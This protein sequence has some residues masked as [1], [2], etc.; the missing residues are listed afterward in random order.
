MAASAQYK[1][2]SK[3]ALEKAVAEGYYISI[4]PD[5]KSHSPKHISNHHNIW[6]APAKT[7]VAGRTSQGNPALI[8]NPAYGIVGTRQALDAVYPQIIREVHNQEATPAALAEVRDSEISSAQERDFEIPGTPAYIAAATAKARQEETKMAKGLVGEPP[9]TKE[10]FVALYRHARPLP[11]TKSESRPF[12]II[13]K[14][15]EKISEKSGSKKAAK[16]PKAPVETSLDK[17]RKLGSTEKGKEYFIISEKN[18][19]FSRRKH[20][21]KNDSDNRKNYGVAGRLLFQTSSQLEAAL[22]DLFGENW[23][24]NHEAE[25]LYREGLASL[26]AREHRSIIPSSSSAPL[27]T[28]GFGGLGL[29]SQAAPSGIKVM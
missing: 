20:A 12:N 29:Q 9:I 6:F 3:A 10:Q 26:T 23:R 16:G 19:K 7:N 17:Y 11:G 4:A 8:F 27:R 2:P 13:N 24:Q 25:A 15:G 18:G 5:G 28:G 14:K 22:A 1:A 21:F